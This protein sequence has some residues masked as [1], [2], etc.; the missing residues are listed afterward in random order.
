M[1][2]QR[3]E[4]ATFLC[5]RPADEA[6]GVLIGLLPRL[7]KPAHG[8]R[9]LAEEAETWTKTIER[10]VRDRRLREAALHYLRELAPTQ[11]EQVLVHQDLHGEN[12]LAAQREPWL[13]VDP[14]PPAA[15]REFAAAPIVRSFQLG[16]GKRDVLYRLGRLTAELGLDRGR[17]RGWTVAQTVAWSGGSD[18]VDV[19]IETVWWL[20]EDAP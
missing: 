15:E 16:H 20:L 5:A 10:D 9:P 17:A 13:V 2:I 19:R 14:K 12:V 6:L 4:T 18:Y 11:G 7:W 8:F 1:L 3:C